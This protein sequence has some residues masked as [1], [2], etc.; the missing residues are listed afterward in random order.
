MKPWRF[1]VAVAVTWILTDLADFFARLG[2]G[3]LALAGKIFGTPRRNPAWPACRI[4]FTKR[5]ILYLARL[6]RVELTAAR[7]LGNSAKELLREGHPEIARRAA[8][9]A[10]LH[11]RKARR[12]FA[13]LSAAA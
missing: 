10:H 3:I 8:R 2:R 11:W 7:D 4:P 5:R 12:V 9:R 1:Y 6:A 13:R